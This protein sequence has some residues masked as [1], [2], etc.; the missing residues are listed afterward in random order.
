MQKNVAHKCLMLLLQYV[1]NCAD[2][3]YAL[4][5]LGCYFK[6]VFFCII[7]GALSEAINFKAFLEFHPFAIGVAFFHFSS[8]CAYAGSK[9]SSTCQV[10][11]K[12]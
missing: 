6:G 5:L 2:L 10:F 4:L 7:F 8:L 1:V 9:F 12:S 3:C 11:H